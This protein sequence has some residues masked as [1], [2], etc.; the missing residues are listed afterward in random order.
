MALEI[1]LEREEDH[2]A[3]EELTRE[4][5][6]NVYVPGASE[7]FILHNL[8]KTEAFIREL[9]FVAIKDGM[10]AG[11]IVYT[12][13]MIKDPEGTAHEMVTFGP[14]SVLPALQ[15]QGVGAALLRHS[16]TAAA[17]MGFKATV[18]YGH[19]EY[20]GKFGFTSG[21]AYGICS[22]DGRYLKALQVKE[23][24]KG[25]LRGISGRFFEDPVFA[26]TETALEAFDARFPHKEKA[27][28]ETQKEFVRLSNALA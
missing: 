18:I 15:R 14:L 20:Y 22:A 26:F 21:K 16:Q 1:R 7:H 24:Y 2:N 4:A 10:L 13:S 3:V 23:H 27:V 11:N 5:F 9:D 19:P 25:A 8:R 6:W 12:R 28:T 17:G